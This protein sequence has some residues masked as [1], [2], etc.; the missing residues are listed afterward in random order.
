MHRLLIL[1]HVRQSSLCSFFD[2]SGHKIEM[3]VSERAFTMEDLFSSCIKGRTGRLYFKALREVY[4]HKF[5]TD[6]C[7]W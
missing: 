2:F 1:L 3:N 6:M 7:S 5:E 4:E